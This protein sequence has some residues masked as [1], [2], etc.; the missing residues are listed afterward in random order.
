MLSLSNTLISLNLGLGTLYFFVGLYL[1]FIKVPKNEYYSP[2]K[3][4]SQLLGGAF[5]VISLNLYLKTWLI[6]SGAGAVTIIITELLKSQIA[7]IFFSEC[8]FNLIDHH[9]LTAQRIRKDWTCFTFMA[10]IGVTAVLTN[11]TLIRTILIG[12]GVVFLTG[13]FVAML[14]RFYYRWLRLRENMKLHG[15]DVLIKYMKWLLPVMLIVM[16]Y[17]LIS[18]YVAI[19]NDVIRLVYL[20]SGLIMYAYVFTTLQYNTMIY[21]TVEIAFREMNDRVRQEKRLREPKI[22]QILTKVSEEKLNQWIEDK[23]YTKQGITVDQL[24]LIVGTNRSYLSTYINA[25]YNQT[26]S[27]WLCE[28]RVIYSKE[29]ILQYPETMFSD[30]G[31]MAGFSSHSYYNKVFTKIVGISPRKWRN[32]HF[33]STSNQS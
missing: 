22:Q 24:A 32:Q 12:V 10:I 27:E 23:G 33:F 1:I 11:D 21:D 18:V 6:D 26:F 2:L 13:Y 17:G 4:T 20:I 5:M 30:I 25:A 8:S 15:E 7:A 14:R 28:L 9:Y 19:S 16:L 29:L 31:M 3:L